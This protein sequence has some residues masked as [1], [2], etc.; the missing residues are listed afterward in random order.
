MSADSSPGPNEDGPH[1]AADSGPG[2]NGRVH[3][4]LAIILAVIVVIALIYGVIETLTKAV[5]LFG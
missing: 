3:A 2:A 1:A 4:T 5:A